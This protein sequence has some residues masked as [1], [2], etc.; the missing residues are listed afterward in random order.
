MNVFFVSPGRTGTKSIS[1]VL[2]TIDGFTSLHESRV[3]ELGESRIEYPDN[4]LESDNRL[5]WFMPQLT[6]KYSDKALLVIVH[7]D[8][9][10]VARSY[11]DRWYKINIMKGYSQGILLRDLSDNNLDVCRDYVNHVYTTLD[12]F[13]DSWKNVIE[14]NI[15]DP[16]E[17]IRGVLEFI[18]KED[19]FEE[20]IKELKTRRSNKT[21]KSFKF[22]LSDFKFNMRNV[23]HDLFG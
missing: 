3:Q 19:Y 2:K 6:K 10:E 22:R 14:M 7:R 18:G 15:K 4:H 5:T 9:E 20:V 8:R 11:N 21:K 23:L 1:R 17:G 12:Y 13:K 16:D